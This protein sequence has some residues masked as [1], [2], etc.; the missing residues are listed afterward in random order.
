MKDNHQMRNYARKNRIPI[1]EVK[2]E[3]FAAQYS[4]PGRTEEKNQCNECLVAMKIKS[5]AILCAPPSFKPA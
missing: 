1:P 3:T 4:S 5:Q 2:N